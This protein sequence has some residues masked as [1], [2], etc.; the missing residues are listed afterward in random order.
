MKKLFIFLLLMGLARTGFAAI[1]FDAASTSGDETGVNPFS[2]SH[3]TGTLTNGLLIVT[4]H[5]RGTSGTNIA[6]SGVT[7]NS[8]AMTKAREDISETAVGSWTFMATSIWY[9]AAPSSGANTVE[10]TYAGTV[11]RCVGGGITYAGM[12]QSSPVGD[13]DM[14]FIGSDVSSTIAV[15]LTTTASDSLIVSGVYSG[16]S[17]GVTADASMTTRFNGVIGGDSQGNATTEAATVTDYTETWTQ[18]VND[19]ML[20]TAVELKAAVATRRVM[21]IN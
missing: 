13:T 11:T 9:L 17:S 19:W 8:T 12:M 4:V 5:G 7:Y 14:N 1:S 2:W 6:V 3:T 16:D 21:L 15:T 10:V 18:T 20:M